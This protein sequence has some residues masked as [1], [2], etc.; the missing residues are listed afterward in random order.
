MTVKPSF[1]KLVVVE[2]PRFAIGISMLSFT[3][4]EIKYFR[5]GRPYCY[6][7]HRS[8][9]KSSFTNTIFELAIVLICCSG[10]WNSLSWMPII[11]PAYVVRMG[12]LKMQDLTKTD[13]E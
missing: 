6:S 12:R 3:V 9:T 7:G 1:S 2:N 8:L 13:H 10:L 11:F 4:P 5:V